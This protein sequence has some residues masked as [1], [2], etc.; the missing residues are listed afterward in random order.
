MIHLQ[1]TQPH[2]L[3]F[4]LYLEWILLFI[5]A[6]SEVANI[7]I[8]Q[9]SRL[10]LLNLL[11]LSLFIFIRWKLP[12]VK[13]SQ[14]LYTCLEIG[15]I[16]LM[17]L[18]GGIRLFPLLYIV[19]VIRNCLIL[20]RQERTIVTGI[21]LILCVLTLWHR[22]HSITM[23]TML[24]VGSAIFRERLGF[25]WF[26]VALMFAL[27][28][29]FLQCLVNAVLLER[30]SRDQ[31]AV[32]SE[33]LRQYAL[34]IEELA[35]VQERNRIAREIHDSLGHSLTVFNLHLEAALQLLQSDPEETRE[36]LLEAKQLGAT[37]L[38]EVRESVAAL[39]TNPLQGQSLEK[40]ITSLIDD[41]SRTTGIAPTCCL[42]I[43]Q[44]ISTEIK[45]AVYRIVQ[46]ALTNICKYAVATEVNICIQITS[47]LE[48]TIADNGTGFDPTQNTTG[49]G[50]Q[51]MQ[52]RTL[53]LAGHFKLITAPQAGCKIVAVLPLESK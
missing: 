26:S 49:F 30:R 17:S 31:L 22:F 27:C 29:I 50:L 28:I 40:A 45:T 18:V 35:T 53:A 25:F 15:L 41:F 21:A 39:R 43:N 14:V 36:L 37:A 12:T 3:Q 16:L 51:G 7:Q 42:E 8:F 19:L 23:L 33:R 32:A 4:L 44:P 38:R 52:E 11:G 48:I 6:V 10:P 13:F 9:M 20:E 24:P 5:V 2:P 34:Q 46:E 47:A 1:K